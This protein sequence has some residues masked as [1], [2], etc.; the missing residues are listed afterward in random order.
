MCCLMLF[1]VLFTHTCNI[2]CYVR[3]LFVVVVVAV[4]KCS[5]YGVLSTE[6]WPLTSFRELYI[7]GG[8]TVY[9]CLKNLSEQETYHHKKLHTKIGIVSTAGI[10]FKRL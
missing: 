5:D 6:G 4:V 9:H 2:I 8:V 3:N 10:I 7:K 1:D